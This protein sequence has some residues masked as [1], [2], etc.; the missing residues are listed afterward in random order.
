M[1]QI[2]AQKWI[3]TGFFN[4]MIVA[5]FGTLMRYKIAYSFPWVDQKNLQHAHSHFA[6][7]GWITLV[8]M[9]LMVHKI[10]S[11]SG[12]NLFPKYRNVLAANLVS[13][14]G[15]LL[16]FPVQGYGA[17]SIFFSTASILVSFWFAILYW[18]DLNRMPGM[19]IP[20][21][22]FK[23]AIIFAVISSIGTFYLA[24]LMATKTAGSKTYLA[25]VYY[26]LH[27][28]YNGWFFFACMGLFASWIR[29][30]G[31]SEKIHARI[32]WLFALACVPAYFLSALWLPM[33]LWVYVLVV[34]AAFSQAI[35]WGI[36][37][38]EIWPKRRNVL[39]AIP[40]GF[41]W[42]I[43]L[44]CIA[45]TI[46]LLLQLG[47]TVP[48]L[49]KLAFGFRPIVIGYLHLVLLAVISLFIIG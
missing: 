20:A 24:Y 14:Y 46:K 16:S 39:R 7:T 45:N 31:V 5:I 32:F 12:N 13:A 17:V 43:L 6:F 47:S 29:S 30:A 15:M 37:C 33:P 11:V 34:L 38:K 48:A 35:G 18:K 19:G 36:L 42:I 44:G 8:L 25:S 49:S 4:L 28:Q 1:S 27:F 21:W 22:W 40:S 10:S 3:S 23:A 2:S 9:A 41:W 26:Y